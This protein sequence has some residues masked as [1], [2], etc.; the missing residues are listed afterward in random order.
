MIFVD[1]IAGGSIDD[2]LY[3]SKGRPV[4]VLVDGV[5]VHQSR[6]TLHYE[7]CIGIIRHFGHDDSAGK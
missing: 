5:V 1:D 6:A 3:D 4:R 2:P 7:A